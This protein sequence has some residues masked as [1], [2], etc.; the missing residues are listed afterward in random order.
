M[1]RRINKKLLKELKNEYRPHYTDA[2]TCLRIKDGQ[3]IN[4]SRFKTAQY[5]QD[6]LNS[7]KYIG[8]VKFEY[9][10]YKC[11][12]CQMWHFGLKEW[13]EK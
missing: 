11:P 6:Q 12:V 2:G 5:A 9:E 1:E 10:V 8:V 3:H 13:R 4:R 7:L